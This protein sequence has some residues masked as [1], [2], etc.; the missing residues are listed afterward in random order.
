MDSVQSTNQNGRFQVIV[1]DN[2]SEDKT[3]EIVNQLRGEATGYQVPDPKVGLIETMGG[4]Q[5]AMDGITCVVSIL[6]K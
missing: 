4:A 2:A 1:I 3:V 5:P 6:G